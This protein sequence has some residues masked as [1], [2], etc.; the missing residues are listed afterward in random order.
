MLLIVHLWNVSLL[1]QAVTAE[2]ISTILTPMFFL[3][4]SKGITTAVALTRHPEK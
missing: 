2:R 1:I 3:K 4:K